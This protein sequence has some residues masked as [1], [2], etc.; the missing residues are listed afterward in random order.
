MFDQNDQNQPAA[1]PSAAPVANTQAP[2]ADPA[3]ASAPLA[4][5]QPAPQ[6]PADPSSAPVADQS[7][8]GGSFNTTTMAPP[9][10]AQAP[11]LELPSTEAPADLSAPAYSEPSSGQPTDSSS[12]SAPNTPVADEGLL[13]LKQ[14][15]L[16]SLSPLL[17]QLEQTPEEKFRTTMML[18]QASDDQSLIQA[19]YDAANSITDEKA[20]AQAL[21]DVVNEINYFTQNKQNTPAA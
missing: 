21:L 2:A 13:S 15:A 8:T 20:K 18:I 7:S 5:E 1:D 14:Q 17:N 3:M 12:S 19:A 11:A 10:Q 4:P 6:A 9:E 16:Q